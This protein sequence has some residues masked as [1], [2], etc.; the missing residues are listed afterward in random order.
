M[1]TIYF[2]WA[3]VRPEMV[4]ATYPIWANRRVLGTPI[5][6]KIATLNDVM[7]AQIDALNIPNCDVKVVNDKEGYN[8]AVTVLSKE[9]EANDDDIII[10]VC[11][12]FDAP[13][14]WD[15]FVLDK[16][17]N[18]DGAL[19]LDDGYQNILI[20]EG[21]MC[22]TIACLTFSTLKKLNKIIFH[23][24]YNH[25]FSD[26][27]AFVNFKQLGILWDTRDTDNMCFRH[28]RD[29]K[30]YD[31]YDRRNSEWWGIDNANYLKRLQM[32]LEE[33]LHD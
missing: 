21:C 15:K 28:A 10:T 32:S 16:F 14:G 3:T 18:F 31:D 5:I 30:P 12:D 17:E 19:F 6:T 29:R 11:D 22:I 2:L 24:S 8:H 13:Q 4:K 7:K 33:R 26:T 20:K 9:L 1:K 25:F 23:P 27:E